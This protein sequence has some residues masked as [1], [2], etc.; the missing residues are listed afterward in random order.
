M[1][2]AVTSLAG[3][4]RVEPGEIERRLADV[5]RGEHGGGEGSVTRAALWNVVAHTATESDHLEAGDV[6]GDVAASIPQRTILIRSEPH[7]ERRLESWIS[8]QCQVRGDRRQV[9]SEQVAITAGGESIGSIPPLVHSLLIPDM[10]VALWWIGPLVEDDRGYL[11]NLLEP[12]DRLI[13]DSSHFRSAGELDIVR[14]VAEQ[15]VTAPADLNWVRLEEW[16]L[17]TATLFETAAGRARLRA[18]RSV[19]VALQNP[20]QSLLY[21]SWLA[22]QSG[23]VFDCA[24][25]EGGEHR[26]EM[27][28][29]DGTSATLIF[30]AA[31]GAILGEWEETGSAGCVTRVTLRSTAALLIRQLERPAADQV[32]IRSL[33]IAVR[34]AAA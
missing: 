11:E 14:R 26:V 21:G 17:A 19:R 6:L 29:D 16:R 23:D 22:A 25:T 3:K 5:W 7:A 8:A 9:C 15:T 33:P 13:V 30:D 32:F 1:E 34:M 18:I 2:A 4:V 27:T 31:Q 24:L 12:A 28:F 20:M 10:P